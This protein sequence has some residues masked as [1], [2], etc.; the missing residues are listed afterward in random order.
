MSSAQ[1]DDD[2]FMTDHNHGRRTYLVT[3]SQSDLE[4]FPTRECFGKMVA[5]HFNAGKAKAKVEYFACALEKHQDGHP[6]YHVALKLTGPKK[7]LR[8]KQSIQ[9]DEGIVVNFGDKH[10][11]YVMAFRYVCK[12]DPNPYLSDNHTPLDLIRTPSSRRLST[13]YRKSQKQKR[14]SVES[15]QEPVTPQ[16][17]AAKE[18][19]PVVKKTRTTN[20]Q[21]SEFVEKHNIENL[22][23]LYHVAQMRREDGERDLMEFI[24]SRT[25]KQLQEIIEKTYRVKGAAGR[26][27]SDPR[28]RGIPRMVIDLL[29]RFLCF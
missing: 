26:H 16:V 18:T 13:S 25:E 17:A 9:A 21:V 4:K 6:H 22:T 28:I 15:R 24:F 1:H 2:D 11:D 27:E 10:D 12:E 14:K 5:R 23:Q 19:T 8:V 20:L 7:W 3:Y 29:H